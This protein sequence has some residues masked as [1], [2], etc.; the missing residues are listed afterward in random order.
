MPLNI[1]IKEGFLASRFP[2]ETITRD[3]L[4]SPQNTYSQSRFPKEALKERENC[5]WIAT[6]RNAG[7]Y[8]CTMYKIP[9]FVK[10]A[11]H[12][13]FRITIKVIYMRFYKTPHVFHLL[14]S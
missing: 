4:S 7:C 8:T 11:K 6:Y 3:S 5:R 10:A 1:I 2:V 9:D 12:V 13:T 14:T